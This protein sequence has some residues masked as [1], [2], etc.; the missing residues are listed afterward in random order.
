MECCRIFDQRLKHFVSTLY[1]ST[2]MGKVVHHFGRIEVQHRGSPHAHILLWVD[3]AD[4]DRVTQE[5]VACVPGV[6]DEHTDTWVPPTD[7][8]GLRLFN[9]VTDKQMHRCRP[10][11]CKKNGACRYGFPYKPCEEGAHYDDALKQWVYYRP[12]EQN[13]YVVPYHPAVLLLWGAHVNVQRVVRNSLHNYL[14]KYVVKSE[15]VGRLDIN[16]EVVSLLGFDEAT[17]TQREVI[18]MLHASQVVSATDAA[19]DLLDVKLVDHSCSFEFE[20][21]SPP[22]QRLHF[23]GYSG[24]LPGLH[25]VTKYCHRPSTPEFEDLTFV[26]YYRRFRCLR[27]PL[28]SPA[29]GQDRNGLY[30][31]PQPQG[32]VV[33]FSSHHPR[34]QTEAFFFNVLLRRVSFRDENDLRPVYN[35]KTLKYFEECLRRGIVT[36]E[37]DVCELV[38]QYVK[39]RLYDNVVD[40][41]VFKILDD[42]GLSP[43]FDRHDAEAHLRR[44]MS[45]R[46]EEP[47]PEGQHPAEPGRDGETLSETLT[48]EQ[49]LILN[50]S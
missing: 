36:C 50:N 13:A 40:E 35:G 38:E 44:L 28:K 19:L 17:D 48:E 3:E 6:C 20:N 33:S 26:E 10:G 25:P 15:A 8:T 31:Y 30:V 27:K 18:A 12:G 1:S 5:I 42:Y 11:K 47:V 39:Y 45:D 41:I 7:E 14:V 46:P 32:V 24:D 23:K 29:L 49:L 22:E 43:G 4:V 9:L 37:A 34:H 21:S 16:D 2:M